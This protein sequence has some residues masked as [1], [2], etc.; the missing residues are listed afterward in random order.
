M[1]IIFYLS[2]QSAD[3]SS[4]QSGFLLNLIMKIFGSGFFTQFIIRK[5]AHFC[6]FTLLCFLFNCSFYFTFE[7]PKKLLSLGLTSLYA[8]SD[9]IHQIFIEG[10]SCEFRDWVID[11]LGA[12]IGLI[13]FVLLSLI[14]KKCAESKRAK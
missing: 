1:G 4:E 6:E 3:E 13:V 12:L 5:L 8:L 11:T 7:K 10:R 14:I 2:S 9:E